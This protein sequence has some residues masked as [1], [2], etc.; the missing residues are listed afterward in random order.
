MYFLAGINTKWFWKIP[1]EKYF[2]P[3]KIIDL[4]VKSFLNPLVDIALTCSDSPLILY[5]FFSLL[6]KS[7]FFYEISNIIF[8]C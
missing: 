8:A 2:T 6:S 5:G 4:F 3:L 1:K 7:I